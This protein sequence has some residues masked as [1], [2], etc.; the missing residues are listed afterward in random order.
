MAI[1]SKKRFRNISRSINPM[2]QTYLRVCSVL[3][4]VLFAG[5]SDNGLAHAYAANKTIERDQLNG[6]ILGIDPGW[7]QVITA[8][9]SILLTVVFYFHQQATSRK[10]AIK[11]SCG[12]IIKEIEE[13]EKIVAGKEYEKIV[14]K[15]IDKLTGQHNIVKYTNAYLDS[16]AY[17]SV[18]FS[19]F[20]TY[21]SSNAQHKLT[22]LYGRI[23]SRNKFIFYVDQL[24]DLYFL[25]NKDP[26][27]DLDDWYKKVE[28]YDS[29]LTRWEEEICG[30]LYEVNAL[31]K[32]EQPK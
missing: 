32:E 6:L 28:R 21:F 9:V 10:E 4:V 24:Q 18:L 25:H 19:G 3:A 17:K 11:R 5:V 31:V 23:H 20:F 27:S 7:W 26:K 14:Y 22:L 29:L 8:V 2:V 12:A 16:E 30:L 13:N 15:T 1:Q